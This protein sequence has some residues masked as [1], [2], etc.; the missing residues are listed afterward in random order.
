MAWGWGR[1]EDGKV[2]SHAQ[3]RGELE[4]VVVLVV[5]A[6]VTP[7]SCRLSEEEEPESC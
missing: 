4:R 2:P 3:A 6:M 7:R 5:L 1:E